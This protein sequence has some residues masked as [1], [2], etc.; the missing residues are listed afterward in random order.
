[1]RVRSRIGGE[2]YAFWRDFVAAGGFNA[3]PG[4]FAGIVAAERVIT[5]GS[6]AGAGAVAAR[7][8]ITAAKSAIDGG[9]TRRIPAKATRRE[10][11]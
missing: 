11:T 9:K 6:T 5:G 4:S 7:T 8:A 10:G 2:F 1:V 3:M